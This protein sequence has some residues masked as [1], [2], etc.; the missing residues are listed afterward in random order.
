MNIN[1]SESEQVE[2]KAVVLSDRRERERQRHHRRRGVHLNEY[3][4]RYFVRRYHKWARCLQYPCHFSSIE[5]RNCQLSR[6]GLDYHQLK[7]ELSS[8]KSYSVQ[9]FGLCL[10]ELGFKKVPGNGSL[11][12]KCQYFFIC[13]NIEKAKIVLTYIS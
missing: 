1:L 4:N 11:N 6:L 10:P 12:V 5:N 13:F 7:L 9:G 8:L 2:T 3:A